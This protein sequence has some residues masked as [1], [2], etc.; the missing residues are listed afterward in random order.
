MNRA[1]QHKDLIREEFTRQ[2]AAYAANPT[3]SDP[4]RVA[5]LIREVA[6]AADARVLDIATGPGYVALGFA[7]VCHEVVGVDLT[8]APLKIADQYRAE[9]ALSNV[10]FQVG[11]AERLSFDDGAFDVVV[12][13]LALHHVEEPGRVLREMARV[14]RW[15]GTVA[16]ED[17]VV[18][19][20]PERAAYQNRFERLRDPTHTRGLSLSQ[21]LE[22]MTA[23]GLD[24]RNVRTDAVLQ[25]AERWLD[26]AH[27]PAD[28]ADDVR[29]ML[30]RD[31]A[32]DLSGVQPF[33]RDGHFFFVH[34]AATVVARRLR[35]A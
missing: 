34:R 32:A 19:E 26:N 31:A 23:A 29:A 15:S 1:D 3:V 17:L 11:D 21:L 7:A 16:I 22:L 20:H 18:S 35:D 30:E 25:D 10:T 27:T 2:A 33:Q 13:R 28:R 5:R 12:C 8:E 4:E 6:P 24:T 9:R 14:C